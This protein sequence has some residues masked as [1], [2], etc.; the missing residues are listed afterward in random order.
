MKR[1]KSRAVLMAINGAGGV[2]Q[3]HDRRFDRAEWPIRV[4]IEDQ[5]QADTW[6]KYLSSE[7]TAP[8]WNSGVMAQLDAKENSGSCTVSY[9]AAARES[10][11]IMVW[12]RERNGPLSSRSGC[13]CLVEGFGLC[14]PHSAAGSA[15]HYVESGPASGTG[16]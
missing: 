15:S 5:K 8:G 3:I 2:T 10:Q 12:E 9:G 4:A 13:R 16:A 6:F 1:T 11:L 14:S 7:C